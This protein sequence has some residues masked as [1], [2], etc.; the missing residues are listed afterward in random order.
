MPYS[1]DDVT[2]MFLAREADLLFRRAKIYLNKNY[3]S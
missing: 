2:A 1:Y 3:L